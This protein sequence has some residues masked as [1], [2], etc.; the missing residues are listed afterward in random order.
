MP[1]DHDD[2][3]RAAATRW[4]DEHLGEHLH[5]DRALAVKRCAAHLVSR[6]PVEPLRAMDI[7]MQVLGL[8]EHKACPAYIDTDRTTSHTLFLVDPSGR[9]LVFTAADLLHLARAAM[10]CQVSG[11]APMTDVAPIAQAQRAAAH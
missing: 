7:A 5:H 4:F 6:W 9:G 2:A 1:T 8:V 11:V 3:L 10:A